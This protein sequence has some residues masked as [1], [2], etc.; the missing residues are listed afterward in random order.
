MENAEHMT[1]CDIIRE[2]VTDLN[3]LAYQQEQ[4]LKQIQDIKTQMEDTNESD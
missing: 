4:I 3:Y 2:L 1:E